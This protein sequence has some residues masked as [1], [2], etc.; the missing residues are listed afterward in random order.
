MQK[1]RFWQMSLRNGAWEARAMDAPRPLFGLSALL[2]APSPATVTVVEG[3]KCVQA[4]ADLGILAV[5]SCGG[6]SAPRQTDWST[7]AG[8]N[9]VVIPDHDTA[10]IAYA[11]YVEAIAAT[12]GA[13]QVTILELDGL[14][15]GEDVVDWIHR[16]RQAGQDQP[17]ILEA[18][19]SEIDAAACRTPSDPRQEAAQDQW[20]PFPLHV[21]PKVVRAIVEQGAQAQGVD[22][23][24]WA[25]PALGILAGCIGATR[26]VEAK[27]TWRE[28]MVLWTATVAPSGAGKSE[29]LRKLLEPVR[30]RDRELRKL[31]DER[32][33][34]AQ[35]A[36]DEWERKRRKNRNIGDPR[37]D[38]PPLQCAVVNDITI[39]CLASRLQDNPR[40]LLLAVEELAQW[41]GS[42]NRYKPGGSDESHWL[43]F[44]GA[45][46]I[47]VDRRAGP[48]I[49]VLEAAVSLVGTIQPKIA[50]ELLGEHQRAS[51]LAA[52]LLLAQPPTKASLWSDATIH[53]ATSDAWDQLV[54]A[55][56]G[57][58]AKDGHAQLL[59]LSDSAT[60][61]FIP[62]HDDSARASHETQKLG[63]EELAS[64]LAKMRG[65]AAR[66]SLLFALCEAADAG[67][68]DTLAA[69]DESAMRSAIDLTLWFEH[70]IRRLYATWAGARMAGNVRVQARMDE[71]ILKLLKAG[72]L[73]REA[74]RV[75]LG[76][77]VESE[78]LSGARDR[79]VALGSISVSTVHTGGR[80]SELWQLLE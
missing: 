74:I 29:A 48:S 53:Q 50:R 6:A 69:V 8:R 59:P 33:R 32:R 38:L 25:L 40:G 44:H 5:T 35:E 73:A 2:A 79:L 65:M 78:A 15:D 63:D 26:C 64:A 27:K 54:H 39:E 22:P 80:P 21:L 56:L 16:R 24:F 61:L 49:Q 71:R 11:K 14:Q 72:P 20:K 41:L 55:L 37:P 67:S 76:G 43:A 57:L 1:K 28:A 34:A 45:S 42:F 36:I 18:L 51:G 30:R 70:E 77:R 7:L 13:A 12:V 75:R 10:G 68:A 52:R 46:P 60:Q 4:L 31:S 66:F 23:T 47:T 62:F 3:E 58:E 17:T 19:R 9:L